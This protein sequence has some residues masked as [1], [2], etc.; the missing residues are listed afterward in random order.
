MREI[1]RGQQRTRRG[2]TGRQAE[3]RNDEEGLATLADGQVSGTIPT[4]TPE[5]ARKRGLR[6]RWHFKPERKYYS[7]KVI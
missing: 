4:N 2:P 6:K 5:H 3:S 1:R 7:A